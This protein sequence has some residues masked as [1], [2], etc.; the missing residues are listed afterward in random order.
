MP[1]RI[2]KIL[3]NRKSDQA[4]NSVSFKPM[5]YRRLENCKNKTPL[6]VIAEPGAGGSLL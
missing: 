4:S 2:F 6:D 1:F 5:G 3:N